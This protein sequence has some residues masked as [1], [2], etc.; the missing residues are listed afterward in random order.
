[1]Q[2]CTACEGAVCYLIVEVVDLQLVAPSTVGEVEAAVFFGG[3]QFCVL[4]LSE[5]RCLVN[6][7]HT[8]GAPHPNISVSEVSLRLATPRM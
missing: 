3:E 4:S 6:R 7:S 8:L 2:G 5:Q 1:M